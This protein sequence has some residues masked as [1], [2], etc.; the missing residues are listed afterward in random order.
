VVF[1]ATAHTGVP[2]QY[3]MLLCANNVDAGSYSTYTNTASPQNRH[4]DETWR[5]ACAGYL[6]C[7]VVTTEPVL[8]PDEK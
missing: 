4:Q 1:I 7:G 6:D 5:L 8:V 2:D 3:K